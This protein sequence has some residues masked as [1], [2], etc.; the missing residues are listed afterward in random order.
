[1]TLRKRRTPLAAGGLV[2]ALVL[3]ACGGG[4]DDGDNEG[5]SG[6]GTQA[7]STQ[8]GGTVKILNQ[9]DFEHLDPQRNYVT[10]SGNIGRLITR[11]LTLIKENPTGDPELVPDLAS[12]WSSNEDNTEWTFTL[13]DGLHY[14]DGTPVTA[15]DLKYGVERSFSADLAE[16]APYARQYLKGA[17]QYKGPYVDG[18]NGGQGLASITVPDE[19]TITFALNQPVA[20]FDWTAS[21]FTF[22]PVPQ[23]KD[24]KTL[25]DNHPLSTGPYMIEDYVR[26]QRLVLARNPHW[27]E[28]TDEVRTALPDRF[29]VTMGQDAAVVDQRLLANSAE[30]QTA[31]SM[32]VTVQNQSLARIQDPQ[33]ADRVVQGPS[34]CVRYVALNLQKP[35]FEDVR[36]RQAMQYAMN[37]TDFQTAYGGPQFGPVVDSLIT[38]K[39]T[40]YRPDFD[41]YEAPPEG[42]PDRA[43]ELLAEAGQENLSLTLASA[44]T[45][46]SRAAAQGVQAG[47]KRAGINVTIEV[48]PGDNY[49]T[50]IQNDAQAPELMVAGWCADW[51]SPASVILPV[52]GPDNLLEPSTHNTN[53]FSRYNNAEAWA[54][55][56]R[57]ATD[58]ADPAEAAQA[59]AD[60]NET[61]MQESPLV[62][63]INDG[64]IYVTGEKLTNLQTTATF[65]GEI[66]L[67]YVGVEQ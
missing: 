64:G 21:M 42:D 31:M 32:D 17:A 14:E 24:T 6:Q 38:E 22:S 43:R 67:L 5:S 8:K 55:M 2:L 62:T 3:A 63:T 35:V 13:K 7:P 26:G 66:D 65:G 51:P 18:N 46:R 61:I 37:K 10:N 41:P 30:D 20:E 53:N 49:Y 23:A 28:S 54:E 40:G 45:E 9:Q 29:E 12:E 48:I 19:K 11:T 36:V 56:R 47:L 59:W 25:Y 34:L 15:A 27:D 58:I 16:G 1:M 50:T 52:L 44:D 60:L 4:G 39:T 57:I 33:V